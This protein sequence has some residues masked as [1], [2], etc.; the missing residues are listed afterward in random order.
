MSAAAGIPRRKQ[1]IRQ[2]ATATLPRPRESE[3]T[4][5]HSVVAFAAQYKV[6]RTHG[7]TH[8]GRHDWYRRTTWTEQD[9]TEFFARFQRSRG[10]GSKAQYLLCQASALRASGDPSLVSAALELVDLMLLDCPD[11]AFLSNAHHSRAQCLVALRRHEEALSAYADSFL[12]RRARPGMQNLAYLDFAWMILDLNL[13]TRYDEALAILD[14]FSSIGE[15]F[16]LHAYRAA[17]ARAIIWAAKGDLKRARSFAHAALAASAKQESPFR[18]HRRL[19][20]VTAPDVDVHATLRALAAAQP[21]VAA[22]RSSP[23]S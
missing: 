9:R 20:L 13:H 10:S 8:L 21:G 22:G 11:E 12:A 14:E 6:G 15:P 3:K 17:A 2:F 5:C 23:G 7:R 1:G 4:H 16:P 18:Y 19:G